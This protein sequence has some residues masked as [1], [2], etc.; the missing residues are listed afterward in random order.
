MGTIPHRQTT[1][2]HD[3]QFEADLDEALTNRQPCQRLAGHVPGCQSVCQVTALNEDRI[4]HYNFLPFRT[5]L[6]TCS[7][8]LMT[9]SG[10]SMIM[11]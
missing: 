9:T 8:A 2:D 7:I 10:L 3:G 4:V 11:K 5:D 1:R 6:T